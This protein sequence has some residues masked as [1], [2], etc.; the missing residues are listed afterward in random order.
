MPK[1]YN[2]LPT[3]SPSFPPV[4]HRFIE[5]V[6]RCVWWGIPDKRL[7]MVTSK[8]WPPSSGQGWV[9]TNRVCFW[10]PPLPFSAFTFCCCIFFRCHVAIFLCLGNSLPPLLVFKQ[11]LRTQL[12][13]QKS[14]ERVLQFGHFIDGKQG[15]GDFLSAI[16]AST[17]SRPGLRIPC[18]V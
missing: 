4:S 13:R 8:R 1:L 18:L 11:A 2:Q 6:K 14:P 9:H 15:S 16:G 5:G 17:R 12:Q 10:Y 7:K 3:P